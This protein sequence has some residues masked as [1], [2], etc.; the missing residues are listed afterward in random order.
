M[1]FNFNKK[2]I[3][4]RLALVFSLLFALH[5][6]ISLKTWFY[7]EIW[8]PKFIL[9]NKNINWFKLIAAIP[10]VLLFFAS[11]IVSLMI[12]KKK[13]WATLF[14]LSIFLFSVAYFYVETKNDFY[15]METPALHIGSRY[16]YIPIGVRHHYWNWWWYHKTESY[17]SDPNN[18]DKPAFYGIEILGIDLLK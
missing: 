18:P 15:Q 16:S 5:F 13:K 1:S 7:Y 2:I 9:E 11:V 10:S 6:L 12:Y 17:L 3:W 8:T 4:Q 14:L